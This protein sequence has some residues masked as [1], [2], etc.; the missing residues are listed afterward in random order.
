MG[1]EEIPG[2]ETTGAGAPNCCWM[3]WLTAAELSA[4]HAWQTNVMGVRAISGVISNEYFAPQAHW[5]FMKYLLA[6]GNGWLNDQRPRH[7]PRTTSEHALLL[8]MATSNSPRGWTRPMIYQP[9]Q[10]LAI[11]K[12]LL[13]RCPTLWHDPGKA[14]RRLPCESRRLRESFEPDYRPL[15]IMSLTRSPTR[16]L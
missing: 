2:M 16:L 12:S 10:R 7:R 6:T 13:R 15:S 5:I 11:A 8:S 9:H 3:T 14:K 4:P 1:R